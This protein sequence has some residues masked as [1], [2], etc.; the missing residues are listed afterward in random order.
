MTYGS[1]ADYAGWDRFGRT[2]QGEEIGTVSPDYSETAVLAKRM[3]PEWI[4]GDWG[5]ITK[6]NK[7]AKGVYVG[8][9]IIYL[10][11]GMW[12]GHG[13][14]GP[15]GATLAQIEAQVD[16]W[17]EGVGGHRTEPWRKFPKVGLYL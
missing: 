9:N 2:A 4:P 8:E 1:H 5:F 17:M 3:T 10:G 11:Q 12:F 16:S 7:N 6:L 14:T 15:Q 13:A